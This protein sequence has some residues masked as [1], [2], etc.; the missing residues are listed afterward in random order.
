MSISIFGVFN[1]STVHPAR[2][3][4]TELAAQNVRF[5]EI[6]SGLNQPIFVT[7][8]G[9]GSGRLFIIQRAGQ[10]RIQ[11]NG[12]LLSTPFLNIQSIVNS[13]GG[14]QGL[15]ALAFHPNYETNGRFYTVHTEQSK[16]I[17]LSVFTRSSTNADQADPNSRVTLL[18]IPKLYANHNGGTLAFGPDGYLYWSTGDGG[19]GGDPDNNAQNVNSLLG[20]ILRLDVSSPASYSIPP[21]NP[22]YNNPSPSIRK[23]IWGYGL[24]NPWRFSFDRLTGD[25]YLGD[26]G[27]GRR[28]EIDFQS[29]SSGG[30]ENYGW[31]I[32]EGSLCYNPSTGCNQSGKILPVAEYDHTK[33]CSVSGG[34]VYR[35][36]K[37]PQMNGFYFYG[38]FCSGLIYSLHKD[39]QNRWMSQLITDS[40]Y[41]IS[42]FG[43][44]EQGELYMVD[45]SSGKI[46]QVAY[47]RVPAKAALISPSGGVTN[48]QPTFTWNEV[49]TNDQG[50]AATWY[51]LWIDGPNGNVFK[52]WYTTAQANCDGTTCSVTPT[53]F[54]LSG[55]NYTWWIQTW[56]DAG[57]GPWS[58]GLNFNLPAPD[59]P[60]KATL[61][62][63]I[64][65]IGTNNPTYTW[66]EVSTATWYYLWVDG[67]SGNV[68][69]QWY[70]T[71]QANCNGTTCSVA[72]TTPNLAAGAYS[73]KIQTWS[74]GGY[75]PWS[76]TMSFSP[77]PPGKATLVS[78]NGS[79]G[80]STP[81]YTWNDVNGTTWYYLWVSRVNTDGSLTTIHTK[82]Y[83]A[84]QVCSGGTCSLT[85]MGITL[86]AGNYRWWVQTWNDAGYGPWSDGINFSP[87]LPGQATLVSP[88]GTIGTNTPAYTW[89]EVA[90][91]TWY[92]LWV[93]GPSGNMIKTWYTAEQA[94]CDGSTCS[95]T[96]IT[97]RSGAHTWW[98]QTWNNIGYGPWSNRMDLLVP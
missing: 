32:M 1:F 92:Y 2:A 78:P 50:D 69:K 30:G 11:K 19:S 5:L 57:Y 26:V 37:Y 55:G 84:T 36:S 10:I 82:W 58:D 47:I 34:Y 67:P 66:N 91:T 83:E 42:S 95:V 41:S 4:V 28:E 98:I 74:D 88:T 71:N 56:N 7:N 80:T 31:R 81:A 6:A 39:S 53:D 17:V 20:K 59:L 89:N 43:E 54:T 38:D 62:S 61:V 77:T 29:A 76:D 73:W 68:L 27:Q 22:F 48:T 96:S 9:D 24:R 18:T 86:S 60:G 44:D 90:G 65:S 49:P 8:A 46:Y 3:A 16:A 85:P 79:I 23:E 15:L 21:S 13:S 63:P 97:L 87:T 51:Y 12:V 14:E 75:G 64:G 52:Q 25:I 94:N 35:G 93:D 70:A 72:N 45:Y 40:T 33:G